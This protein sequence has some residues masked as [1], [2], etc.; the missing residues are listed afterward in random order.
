MR[1]MTAMRERRMHSPILRPKS[2]R[3]KR[4]RINCGD[5]QKEGGRSGSFER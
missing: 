1:R 5:V 2:M 3:Q 4:L